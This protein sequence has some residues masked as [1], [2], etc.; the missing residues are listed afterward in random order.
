M[1][2]RKSFDFTDLD[3]KSS[4]EK[5]K[6][7]ENKT[8]RLHFMDMGRFF[9]IFFMVLSHVELTYGTETLL[10]SYP[11]LIIDSLA[12]PPAAPV[13]MFS[14]G[15]FVVFTKKT[16]IRSGLLRGLKIFFL[17]LI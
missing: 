14:M 5:E 6:Q 9:A 2:M 10:E 12:G 11:G 7:N 8:Q 15:F 3:K 17:G 13:F 1:E 16:D 4:E